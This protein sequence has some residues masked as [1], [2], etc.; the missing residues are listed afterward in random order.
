MP[1]FPLLQCQQAHRVSHL[2]STG[3]ALTA[4]FSKFKL[5]SNRPLHEKD[6]QMVTREQQ[7]GSD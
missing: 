4:C 3:I 1:E 2:N 7:R 6:A 5:K